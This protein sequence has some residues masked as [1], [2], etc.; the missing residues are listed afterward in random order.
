MNATGGQGVLCRRGLM[1]MHQCVII[2]KLN[3]HTVSG[4][5]FHTYIRMHARTF[6]SQRSS[7][8]LGLKLIAGLI[9]WSLWRLP[10]AFVPLY[11]GRLIWALWAAGRRNGSNIPVKSLL[12]LILLCGA[13]TEILV[14]SFHERSVL[15][16]GLILNAVWVMKGKK[17]STWQRILWLGSVACLA[18]FPL[19]PVIGKK[20]SPVFM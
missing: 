19:A 1:A 6:I 14:N 3:T 13:G 17:L 8:L 11:L 9:G 15:T 18:V 20:Q 12:I 16:L 5:C 10:Y 4:Y 2:L 7:K